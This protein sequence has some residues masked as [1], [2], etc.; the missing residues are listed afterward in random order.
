MSEAEKAQASSAGSSLL[1]RV[2]PLLVLAGIAALVV[3][4]GWH[5]YL[6]LESIAENRDV[7]KSYID[8]NAMLS[9]VRLFMSSNSEAVG[10]INR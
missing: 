10:Q 4:Q 9:S 8:A 6:T 3:S 2:L 7:L 5:K 1:K